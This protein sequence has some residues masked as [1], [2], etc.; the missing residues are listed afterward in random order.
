MIPY[1]IVIPW[2]GLVL[3]IFDISFTLCKH[4]GLTKNILVIIIIIIISLSY[5]IPYGIGLAPPGGGY[6][7]SCDITIVGTVVNKAGEDVSFEFF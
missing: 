7:T 1:R 6:V 4:F 2:F 5:S 3:G